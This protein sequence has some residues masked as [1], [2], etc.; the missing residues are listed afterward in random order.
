MS[1]QVPKPLTRRNFIHSAAITSA[2]LGSVTLAPANWFATASAAMDDFATQR[3]DETPPANRGRIYK[4]VKWGMIKDGKTVLEKFQ[5]NKELGYDGMELVSPSNLDID[6]VVAA[7]QE[8]GLP[9]H[10]LVNQKHWQ[11]R[12]SSP[13]SSQRQQGQQ[14]LDQ[15]LQDARSFGGDSVLLVPGRVKGPEENHDHVWNRSIVEIRKSL[16]LASRLGVRILI[17]N[18]WNGFCETPEQLR[19]YLDEIN[20][21]WVGAYFDIGN[22]RK[23]SPPENWIRVLGNRIVKL[24]VKDW[25]KKG[26]FCKI[27]DGDVDWDEVRKALAEIQFTGWSTAEV[28]GGNKERLADIADR[29]N[30]CLA[31]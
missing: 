10:G 8:T 29:M 25:A 16:P 6:E 13:D 18:V 7:S 9:V 3:V 28:K 26:G 19:D 21:P 30:R 23:F 14:V 2:A 1:K 15:C 11:V 24:D 5:L 12:L 31:I 17:E 27:G 22:V 4:S 20:S